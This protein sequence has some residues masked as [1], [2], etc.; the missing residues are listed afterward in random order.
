MDHLRTDLEKLISLYGLSKYSEDVDNLKN[1]CQRLESTYLRMFSIREEKCLR[2]LVLKTPAV[3]SYK[4]MSLQH[5]MDNILK[6]SGIHY[7]RIYFVNILFVLILALGPHTC[8]KKICVQRK[9]RHTRR[10][11]FFYSDI[12]LKLCLV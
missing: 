1:V 12:L 9:Q 5:R 2:S 4:L 3:S 7:D 6:Y 8:R 11:L 10:K